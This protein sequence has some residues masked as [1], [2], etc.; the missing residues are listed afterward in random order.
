MLLVFVTSTGA[1]AVP[2]Q[3]LSAPSLTVLPL[4]GP[5]N[6]PFEVRVRGL[7]PRER[8][9]LTAD[10]TGVD[11]ETGA[12]SAIV[13][14]SRRGEVDL[15]KQPS[16]G[17]TYRGLSPHGLFCSVL[18]V[19]PEKLAKYIADFP[20]RPGQ[21]ST[22][23]LPLER[24]PITVR[25]SADGRQLGA[26]VTVWRGFAVGTAGEKVSGQ[27][28][29]R[30]VYYPPAHG[31]PVGE[32]VVVLSGSGGGL[33]ETTAALLASNGHPVLALALYNYQD[34][35]KALHLLPLEHVRD[36]A[37]WLAQKSA[38]RKVAVF[39]ISR[40]SEAAQLAAAYF[41]DAFSAVIAEVPS[42][43]IGGALGPGTKPEEAA[44]TVGG[45]PLPPF[46][47]PK[48][49]EARMSALAK[50]PP[51]Y[52]GA[53]DLLPPFNDPAV[54]AASGIPYDRIT[55][56]MLVLAAGA[57]D[58]WPSY[59]SAERIRRRMA[60][61]GKA[62]QAEIHVYPNAGHGMVSVGRGNALSNFV[63]N[64]ALEGYMSVGGTPTGN[65]EASFQAFDAVLQ[66]LRRVGARR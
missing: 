12:S 17:G 14:A 31:D 42:H 65:C 60:A 30:G 18:P 57:D 45:K 19:T 4:E 37:R 38:T 52:R 50:T 26:P 64:P 9:K 44:W 25:A 10:R 11:G 15:T 35:P 43:L 28:G 3:S 66:F 33:F 5:I 1:W 34:L 29:W 24:S 49:D 6:A 48:F 51:G 23:T 62:D 61:L 53:V 22:I 16:L 46:A 41:P 7:K 13:E 20:R 54:E 55:A 21:P 63:Y 59:V 39:G 58:V 8:V 47:G 36:G 32:P 56:S 27:S 40:G 2:A